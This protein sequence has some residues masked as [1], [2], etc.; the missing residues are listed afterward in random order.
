MTDN[1]HGI[2]SF[3]LPYGSSLYCNNSEDESKN[4]FFER[5]KIS[6]NMIETQN[7]YKSSKNIFV[8]GQGLDSLIYD[9]NFEIPLPFYKADDIQNLKY[10]EIDKS[11]VKKS[12]I[13][14]K[15]LDSKIFILNLILNN[16]D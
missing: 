11:I 3:K 7:N 5:L 15:T 8:F 16:I 9:S 10:N 13:I 6:I 1:L 12:S 14:N 4:Q 2:K